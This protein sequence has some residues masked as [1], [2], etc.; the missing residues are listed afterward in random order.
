MPRLPLIPTI[1]VALAVAVMIALGVWQ[2]DRRAEKAVAR[3]QLAANLGKPEMAFPRFPV[4]DEHLFRQAHGFCL[5]VVGWSSQAGR[6]ANGTSGWRQ[7]AECRMRV[8]GPSMPVDMGV[9]QDPKFKPDW[10]GGEV[11]GTIGQAPDARPLLAGIFDSTPRGLML[12]SDKAAPGL[13]PSARPDPSSLPDNHL[14]YAG[15]WFLFAIAAVIIYLLALRR[16]EK[17]APAAPGADAPSGE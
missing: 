2:L 9:S 5:E 17:R 6:T 16:R 11:R 1:I 13:E 14:A 4:G 8:E 7:I 15:Q 3:A 10:K 12:V